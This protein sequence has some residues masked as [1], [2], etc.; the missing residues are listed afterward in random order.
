MF[1]A[2]FTDFFAGLITPENV[3]QVILM[4]AFIYGLRVAIQLFEDIIRKQF[5]IEKPTIQVVRD[6]K[7]IPEES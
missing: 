3:S 7:R 4:F 2:I 5:N 1:E 6:A